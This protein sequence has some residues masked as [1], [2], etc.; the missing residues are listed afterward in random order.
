VRAALIVLVA[1]LLVAPRAARADSDTITIGLFAPTAPFDGTGDRVSFVNAL[2]EH[3][4]SDA[5]GKKVRGK[6]YSSATAFASAV[7]SKDIQY[8]VIDAPYA[9]AL[10][11]PYKVLGAAVRDGSSTV[12]WQLVA[13]SGVS[14]L[15]DLKGKKV[16]VPSIGTKENAFVTN[17]LLDGE[18]EAGYFAKIL[19]AADAKSALTMVSVG[20][21]DAAL[22][23]SGVDIPS[24][25]S[26]VMS[27]GTVGW[28]MFV[29]LPGGDEARTKAFASRARSFSSSGAFSGFTGGD[30][31]K[32][33]SL[34]GSF[35]RGSKKGPMVV[36]PP[37]RLSV[38][39]ILEGRSFS[40][41]LSN[42]LD[43][44]EAP[45]K[46]SAPAQKK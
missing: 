34:A 2:A 41:P 43:L 45:A 30:A 28:P 14:K 8:A 17:V 16:V 39:E 18:V 12:S 42:V 3:L 21:A 7:K 35:G 19:E 37:A 24:G 9:A 26:K 44:I 15:S 13:G 32:Y 10:G 33:K 5:G 23:P 1:A 20:K 46:P 6:V 40:I 22:V 38:R 36:P 11:L 25:M 31:G 29:A 27:L 4:E